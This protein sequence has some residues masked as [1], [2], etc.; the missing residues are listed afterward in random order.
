MAEDKTEQILPQFEPDKSPV[1]NEHVARVRQT[2]AM[3]RFAAAAEESVKQQK[4]MATAFRAFAKVFGEQA[5]TTVDLLRS[6]ER[7]LNR[8]PGTP[9]S[10]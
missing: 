5:A 7:E 1:H 8:S 6:I 2:L 9:S 3:E 4:A 10:D